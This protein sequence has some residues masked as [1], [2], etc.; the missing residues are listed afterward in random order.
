MCFCRV[1]GRTNLA[2]PVTSN[3][4]SPLF[5]ASS[6]SESNANSAGTPTMT[7]LATVPE[8]ANA[9]TNW[10]LS[11]VRSLPVCFERRQDARVH[12]LAEDAE[13]IEGNRARTRLAP[14]QWQ[15]RPHA[16]KAKRAEENERQKIRQPARQHVA[17]EDHRCRAVP[18]SS[19]FI[20]Q[21]SGRA[22]ITVN[23]KD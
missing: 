18:T 9:L 8:P 10:T 20:F 11:P 7:W 21:H 22:A 23:L 16:I 15:P 12:H 17:F 14:R 1:R 19:K 13:S 6:S 3:I 5:C 4:S 2:F